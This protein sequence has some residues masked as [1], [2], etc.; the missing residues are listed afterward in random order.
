MFFSIHI[1]LFQCQANK[2]VGTALLLALR[3]SHPALT[4]ES[5]IRLEL[6]VTDEEELP[7]VWLLAASLLSIW[8]QRQSSNRVQPYLVRTQL[9]AKVNL[10]RNTSY[11]NCATALSEKI[12]LMFEN[13]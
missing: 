10:L 11:L 4:I 6:D 7:L 9:E 12:Q 3:L 5:A 8:E 2:N 13:C 1:D